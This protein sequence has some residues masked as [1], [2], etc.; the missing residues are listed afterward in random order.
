M[1]LTELLNI[2]IVAMLHD[3][4]IEMFGG[5]GGIHN[6]TMILSALA[7]PFQTFAGQELYP[8]PIEKAGIVFFSLIKN[9]GFVDGNKRTACLMLTL[10]LMIYGYRLKVDN[11][12]MEKIV[13]KVANGKISK[14]K[15]FLWIYH[16]I[17][18]L[19]KR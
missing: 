8:T 1:K 3:T 15:V 14:E 12:T 19:K 7:N 2:K 5:A 9:H 4:I 6:Q 11:L 13:L 17:D 10:I 16:N 18:Y